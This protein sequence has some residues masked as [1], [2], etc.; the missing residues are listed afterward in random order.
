MSSILAAASSLRIVEFFRRS[1]RSGFNESGGFSSP[2]PT[3]SKPRW[4]KLRLPVPNVST[5]SCFGVSSSVSELVESTFSSGGGS[6]SG[7]VPGVADLL[8]LCVFSVFVKVDIVFCVA[9]TKD[10]KN[11][12]PEATVR[13]SLFRIAGAFVSSV[14][15]VNGARIEFDNLLG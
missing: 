7:S 14:V 13:V 1:S 15:G 3:L 4:L 8:R 12:P 10:E 6:F 11:P 9:D 2:D 5:A